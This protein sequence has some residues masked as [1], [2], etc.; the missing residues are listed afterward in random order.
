[1]NYKLEKFWNLT[2][3]EVVDNGKKMNYKL[4]KFWN[5]TEEDFVKS[6]KHNEL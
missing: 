3:L 2:A 6:T 1:M 5:V 4:E